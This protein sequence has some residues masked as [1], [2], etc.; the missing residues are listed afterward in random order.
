MPERF[1]LYDYFLGDERLAQI[2]ESPAVLFRGH[3]FT[4]NRLREEVQHWAARLANSG[5]TP[6]DRVALY[7]Y[8]SP[9][10]VASFLAAASLGLIAVPINTFLPRDDVLFIFG[11]SGASVLIA[12]SQLLNAPGQVAAGP[13]MRM[14]IEV[15][16]DSR[17]CLDPHKTGALARPVAET[18]SATPAFILYTSGSTGAPKGVLHTHG[19]I[20]ATVDAYGASVLKLRP[21]DRTYSASRMFFAYGLGNSLSFPLSGAATAVL[22]TDRPSAETVAAVLQEHQPTVFFGVPS[23]YQALIELKRRGTTVDTSSLRLCVSAGEA[24][25][26]R[27]FQDWKRTFG[28]AIVDGIGSTEMLHIFISNLPG[29]ERPGSTGSVVSGYEAKLLDDN[30]SQLQGDGTGSLWVKGASSFVGYWNRPDLTIETMRDGWVRTGDIYRLESGGY[31]HHVGRSDDCFKIKGLWVSPVEVESALI[32]HS[33]VIEAAVIPDFDSTGLATV[34]AFVVIAKENRR[35]AFAEE[36]RAHAASRLAGHKIPSTIT[37][38]D[39]L[40]RTATG[41]VQRFKLRRDRGAGV[42]G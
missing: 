9:E 7:L 10:L 3:S 15:D 30:G 33:D 28:M 22:H 40:P 32:D 39:E 23:L 16:T 13:D 2:G 34:H 1:N 17:H 6:G 26:A 24:L 14:L 42:D 36:L 11:D 29:D 35:A 20:K 21:Q 19:A 38:V 27:V 37:V 4:Y 31:F 18:T 5:V 25:P 41:K 12:E 8:D